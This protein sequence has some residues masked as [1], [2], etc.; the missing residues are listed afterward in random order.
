MIR[1]FFIYIVPLLL[2]SLVHF[3]W[4]MWQRRQK[5]ADTSPTELFLG[6]PWV[7]TLLVGF[8]LVILLILIFGFGDGAAPGAQYLSPRFEDGKI[9]PGGFVD[10][11]DQP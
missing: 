8:I 10:A 6:M 3:G 2:P 9:I 7:W 4:L 1:I 5:G 11:P